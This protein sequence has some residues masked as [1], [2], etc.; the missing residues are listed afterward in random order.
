MIE[1]L[2]WT[3][4]FAAL[5]ALGG[6]WAARYGFRQPPGPPRALA[7]ATLAWVWVTLGAMIL[8][9]L[10][11]LTRGPV[12]AWTASGTALAGVV[13]LLAPGEARRVEAPSPRPWGFAATASVWLATWA[14]VILAVS[15]IM[16][17]TKVVSDGPIYHLYFAARWWKAGRLFLVACPFGENAAT[18]FPAGG[19]VWFAWLMVLFGNDRLARIG[20]GPFLLMAA[21]AAY[22]M[23]RRLG[24]SVPSAVVATAWFVTCLPF[25][26][27]SFEANVDTLFIAGYLTAVY[28]GIR[29]A[30]GD[31]GAGTLTLA[32][33]AA[34]AAWGSKPTATVFIPP[35][36]ALGAA[37]VVTRRAPW[38]SRLGH[39]AILVL[40]PLIP[41]GYWFARN[42]WLSGN[43]L[44]PLRIS[45]FGRVILPGWYDSGAMQK[46]QFYIPIWMWQAFVD[47]LVT[48]LD[49]RMI[50]IWLLAIG[51][52]WAIGRRTGPLDRWTWGMTALAIANVASYWLLIP[53]RTQQRFMLQGLGLVVVPLGALF[54]RSAWLRRFAIALLAVHLL[55][56]QS[57]P[58]VPPDR[59]V[60]W[61]LTGFIAAVP[62]A[63]IRIPL[64]QADLRL[65]TSNSAG[66][67]PLMMTIILAACSAGAAWTWAAFIRRPTLGRRVGA[68]A[69]GLATVAVGVGLHAMAGSD[70]FIYPH[71]TEYVRGWMEL[72]L[73]S[74]PEGARIAYAGTN[75]PYYLMGAGLRNDVRY[76]NIDAHSDWLLHDY[77]LAE[78]RARGD[79]VWP[80]PRP[81]WDRDRIRRDYWAWLANLRAARIQLLVVAR[82]N[83]ADGQFNVEDAEG[84]TIEKVW[85]ESHPEVFQP[86]YGVAERDPQFR[87]YRVRPESRVE[88]AARATDP[89]AGR[90]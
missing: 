59:R 14:A 69:A 78:V 72:E 47:I 51:G 13:R 65:W 58:F 7:T 75:L 64:S 83:P 39:L 85:A 28:F 57:W 2:L 60:P 4:A 44:Y 38:R 1:G 50:P 84:F 3:T 21:V 33:L 8:G 63:P 9:T 61:N 19:D 52:A 73:R 34:G 10:G 90:H 49:F 68:L 82:A 5:I 56:P 26:L 18:Y 46:S 42:A 41:S 15:S 66:M 55:T 23:A 29:Y 16:L 86:I 88:S 76:I 35:L 32:G 40:T 43:P 71:F 12:L 79:A 81:G 62:Q 74:P 20:Q 30:L 48:V 87:I 22:A 25:L 54:D 24:V 77:H 45:A 36:L 70:R 80:T 11:W 27:F 6:D 89:A 53:Y 17:P 37:V 67:K 31:G